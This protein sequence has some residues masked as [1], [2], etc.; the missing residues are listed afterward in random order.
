[1]RKTMKQRRSMTPAY[2]AGA[3]T[4]THKYVKH[5]PHRTHAGELGAGDVD[6]G[7]FR[8]RGSRPD[9]SGEV[10]VEK[11]DVTSGSVGGQEVAGGLAYDRA[12][13]QLR[14]RGI[15]MVPRT[16]AETPEELISNLLIALQDK[17]KLDGRKPAQ[18]A[19]LAG[20]GADRSKA[21]LRG[22][23]ATDMSLERSL[24][25]A[26]EQ[27]DAENYVPDPIPRRKRMALSDGT[28][29]TRARARQAAMEQLKNSG[30]I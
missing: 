5:Q 20:W 11:K 8:S 23:A 2:G 19:D 10:E 24:E 9:E 6:Q 4:V 17:R 15:F 12:R 27:M 1:M 3:E 18:R 29:M 25:A 16:G 21:N 14:S 13:L 22:W 7:R 26:Q 28:V 30:L